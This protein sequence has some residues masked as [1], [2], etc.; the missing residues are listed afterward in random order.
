MIRSHGDVPIGPDQ[1][2]G[3]LVR[4]WDQPLRGAVTDACLFCSTDTAGVVRLNM[5]SFVTSRVTTLDLQQADVVPH[6]S[7]AIGDAVNTLG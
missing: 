5:L 4:I 3:H 1:G 7:H 6:M 2:I